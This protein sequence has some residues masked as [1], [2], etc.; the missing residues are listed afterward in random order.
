MYNPQE[1]SIAI[2]NYLSKLRR[3]VNYE[4]T[5]TLGNTKVV[6]KAKIDDILCCVEG[7]FP[8]EYRD[9]VKKYGITKLKSNVYLTQLHA[10]IKHRFLLSTTNYAVDLRTTEQ[11][12]AAINSTIDSDLNK[13]MQDYQ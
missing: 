11:L 12:I 7:S 1:V 10:A 9:Y 4:S 6:S 13:I 8:Q 5:F 2:K 3:I